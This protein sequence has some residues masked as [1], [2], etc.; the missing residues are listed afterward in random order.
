MFILLSA[1]LTG[2]RIISEV[3]FVLLVGLPWCLEGGLG[4]AAR[5]PP[6]PGAWILCQ[7]LSLQLCREARGEGSSASL[8]G[9]C[10]F[11][12]SALLS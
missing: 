8:P 7:E 2:L 6:A 1:E 12:D 11:P 9:S 10:R 4:A 5:T 3:P